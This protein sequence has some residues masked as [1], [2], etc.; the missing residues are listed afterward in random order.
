MTPEGK[1]KKQVIR[2]LKERGVYYFC[3]VT[4]G[5]GSS[6]VFDI[7]ACYKGRFIGIECKADMKKKAPTLL[8]SCNARQAKALGGI[9]MVVDGTNVG[10]VVETLARIGEQDDSTEGFERFSFW[11]FD[12]VTT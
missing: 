8:Q 4:S 10:H 11:P 2:A 6:G 12:G 1:V 5:Y 3:P 9:V 7:V